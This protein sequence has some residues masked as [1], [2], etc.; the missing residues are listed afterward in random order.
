MATKMISMKIM[1][2]IHKLAD[3]STELTAK[4]SKR[5]FA[6]SRILGMGPKKLVKTP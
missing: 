5:M 1:R 6:T 4:R 3:T 2:K